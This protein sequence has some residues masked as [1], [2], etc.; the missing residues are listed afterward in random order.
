MSSP[1]TRR[2]L[3]TT[4]PLRAQESVSTLFDTRLLL[5][6]DPWRDFRY[7]MAAVS[8]PA[9]SAA[10]LR[11]TGAIRTATSAF[12]QVIFAHAV[13]GRHRWQVGRESGDGRVPFVVPPEHEFSAEFDRLHLRTFSVATDTLDHVLRALVGGDA[14]RLQLS[15]LNRR[16]RNPRLVAET[17]R[18]VEATA[19]ADEQIAASPLMR[20]QLLH[21]AVASFV[22]AYPMI[23]PDAMDRHRPTARAVRAAVAFMEENVGEPISI[24][25]VAVAAGT[26][27]RALQSAFHR[28]YGIPPSAYLRRLRLDG[29]HRDLRAAH[30]GTS[31]VR[32]IA[33]RWG[34]AHT[35]R[36]A[37]LYATAYGEQPS[38][39]LRR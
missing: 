31:T 6:A 24:G 30:P 5:A 27:L 37:Q 9:A 32:D 38:Q 36:F 25:D 14:P 39:T 21:Q 22:T 15:G 3:Q 12:P 28:S 33:V 16:S 35:G 1:L 2:G 26:S 10:A 13:T 7:E 11:F 23:D 29:A 4:D 19:I 20:T 17:L 18:F 8:H 34:F